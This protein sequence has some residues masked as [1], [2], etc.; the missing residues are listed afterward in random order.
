MFLV[1]L[2]GTIAPP[3]SADGPRL[4]PGVHV[5][6]GSPAGKEYA[7]PL[8]SAR[9][10]GGTGGSGGSRFGSGITGTG[11]GGPPRPPVSPS[12]GRGT[13]R[14]APASARGRRNGSIPAGHAAA[15]VP[16]HG[17]GSRGAQDAGSSGSGPASG[18]N[19][20]EWMLATALTVLVI[21]GLGGRLLTQRSGR[22]SA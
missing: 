13:R 9:G 10:I 3:A 14:T 12:A 17:S 22:G 4:P 18:G 5:D 1:A 11:G 19:G 21:G 6:P 20:L 7:V 2:A 8:G 15:G 16:P